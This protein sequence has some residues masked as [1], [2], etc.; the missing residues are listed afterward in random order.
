MTTD[1]ADFLAS[2]QLVDQP[3]GIAVELGALPTALFDW[4]ASLTQWALRRG[5]AGLF[6]STGLGKTIMQC[7]WAQQIPGDVLIL[8]PLAVTQQTIHEAQDKLGMSIQYIRRAEDRREHVC[9]TNYDLLEHFLDLDIQ[10]VVLDESSCLKGI[11]SKRRELL[12]KHFT[13]IPFRL[14]ATAT[15]APNDIA[16][17]AMHAEFLGVM[18]RTA[19]LATFF[20]HDDAGWRLRGHATDAFYR[21]LSSWAMA[22][23]NPADIGYDGSAF[24]L[25][26]LITKEHF[27]VWEG[28]RKLA[29][30]DG[31]L[32]LVGSQKLHGITDRAQVRK[33]TTTLRATYAATL[34]RTSWL[35]Q[36]NTSENVTKLSENQ[37]SHVTK[38]VQKWVVWCGLDDEQNQLAKLLGNA[39][40]SIYGSLAPE[41]KERREQLWRNGDI[42]VI[43]TKPKIFG[44]GINWQCAH[45]QI[46]LGLNDSQE[47]Y[48]QAVRRLWRYG[49]HESVTTHVVL[50]DHERP[51]WENVQHKEREAMQMID[52]L[53]EAVRG[54]EQEA[55]TQTTRKDDHHTTPM[56]IPVWLY[57]A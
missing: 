9:I 39:C 56:Q 19:M 1:Y 37:S 12:F 52:G 13:H 11:A 48:Y 25:P 10:G 26:P 14:C 57:N 17:L 54:Y 36:Q 7:A 38:N 15:P 41:E 40:I 34:I 33:E 43:I 46:F 2:K 55:L 21:W 35:D 16:E 18:T 30:A 45:Q 31:Q 3:T 8:A 20:V 27:L 23:R 28:A 44:W 53:V 6:A 29:D 42:P 49:Q 5:R 51:I 22:L 32:G 47:M 50:S 4:Q 24:A